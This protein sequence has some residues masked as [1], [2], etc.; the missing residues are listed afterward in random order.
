MQAFERRNVVIGG[1]DEALAIVKLC[2]EDCSELGVHALYDGDEVAPWETTTTIEGDYSLFAGLETV[3]LGV[4]SRRT[5]VATNV[6]R[7]VEAAQGK[8]IIFFPARH[9][10]HLVQTGDG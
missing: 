2:S 4:L 8:Q 5:K 1:V 7:V 3:H 10:H 9:D 6:R